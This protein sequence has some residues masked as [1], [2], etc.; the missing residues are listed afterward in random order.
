MT[1]Y[2][3]DLKV[4]QIIEYGQHTTDKDEM[5]AFARQWDP[6]PFHIDEEFAKSTF[7]GSLT[8]SGIHTLAMFT[9]VCNQGTADMAARGAFGYEKVRFLA[10]VKPGDTLD[11][12]SEI[13]Q[14]RLSKSRPGLGIVTSYESLTNQRG[15]LVLDFTV[16][17]L[18]EVRPG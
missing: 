6:R 8:A 14:M 13:T 7:Y 16:S 10:P 4:G 1:V 15:E 9:R 18:I 17:Y 2:Y 11:G 5:V 12:R 3:E